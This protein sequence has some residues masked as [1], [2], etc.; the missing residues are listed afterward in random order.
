MLVLQVN[1]FFFSTSKRP[2][3]GLIVTYSFLQV[4]GFKERTYLEL[5][6]S[7]TDGVLKH[8]R[9]LLNE[10]VWALMSLVWL[11][12]FKN[13]GIMKFIFLELTQVAIITGCFVN[14][15]NTTFQC[16]RFLFWHRPFD[17]G[18]TVTMN[19]ITVCEEQLSLFFKTSD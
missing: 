12:M 11:A 17:L 14:A 8:V 1:E 19:S 9:H 6:L 15:V 2:N 7:D 10:V 5:S 3:Q 4:R 18:D 13:I 16:L